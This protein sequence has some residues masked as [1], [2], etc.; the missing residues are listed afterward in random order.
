MFPKIEGF[1]P[2]MHGENNG[3]KPYEQMVD[4]GIPIPWVFTVIGT[5]HHQMIR[6]VK[7]GVPRC[8]K[9]RGF[10]NLP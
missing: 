6:V 1:S 3:S 10:P 7:G 8:S 2:K 9:G 5:E 4:L